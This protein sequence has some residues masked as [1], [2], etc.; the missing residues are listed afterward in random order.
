MLQRGL[1]AGSSRDC[2]GRLALCVCNN[3]VAFYAKRSSNINDPDRHIDASRAT[4]DEI[5]RS[6]AAGGKAQP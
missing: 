5:R 3:F 6:K 4:A 1:L 2:V